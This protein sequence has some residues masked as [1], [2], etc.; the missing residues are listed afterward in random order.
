M[1][2]RRELVELRRVELDKL[3]V[4]TTEEVAGAHG[5]PRCEHPL[6]HP[7][8]TC[9]TVCKPKVQLSADTDNFYDAVIPFNKEAV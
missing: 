4:N 1:T 8:D 9:S 6:P 7:L 2:P 3:L 5:G